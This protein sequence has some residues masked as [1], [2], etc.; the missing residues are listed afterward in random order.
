MRTHFITGRARSDIVPINTRDAVREQLLQQQ[1]KK[2]GG[3][4]K[5]NFIKP[6]ITKTDVTVGLLISYL[7]K[8]NKELELIF[9]NLQGNVSTHQSLPSLQG[10]AAANGAKQLQQQ[11]STASASGKV[12]CYFERV[13]NP[14]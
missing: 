1:K 10:D 6:S 12:I 13:I 11:S 4:A 14:L 7:P 2:G 9:L 3:G 5:G 8:F